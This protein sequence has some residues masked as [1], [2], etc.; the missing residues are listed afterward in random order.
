MVDATLLTAQSKQR[1]LFLSPAAESHGQSVVRQRAGVPRGAGLPERG[2]PDGHR[3][4]HRRPGGL[5]ALL[6]A[7]PPG[8]RPR[9]PPQAAHRTH[10][11]GPVSGGRLGAVLPPGL[12]LPAEARWTRG[13]GDLPGAPVPA[14]STAAEPAQHLPGAPVT[15]RLPGPSQEHPGCRQ[16]PQQGEE[17]EEGPYSS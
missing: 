11:R 12:G 3:A 5:V 1:L 9:E 14:E 2:H 10:V 16:H 13:A 8:H 4:E 15:G 17:G 7:R 6:A